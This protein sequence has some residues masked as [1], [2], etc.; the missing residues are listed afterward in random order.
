MPEHAHRMSHATYGDYV[1]WPDDERWE[2]IE[3]QPHDMSPTPG[4]RHQQIVGALHARIHN[5]LRQAGR[6][7]VYVAPFD[8]R[9]PVS[10]EPDDDVHSVVQP[11]IAVICDPAKLDDKGCRGA[12]D[13]IIEV[14][15]PSTAAKDQI[16]KLALYE[17]HGVAHYWLVH[18]P[19][20]IVTVY[21]LLPGRGDAGTYGGR[22]AVHA[23]EGTLASGLFDDLVIDWSEV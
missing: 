3:G 20:C 14:L 8:V 15:S 6:C 18:P 23:M 10:D 13:W 4:R 19:D 16:Q 11:D 2:F 12:P 7:E 9:L 1:S 5:Y 17:K 21:T 22:P